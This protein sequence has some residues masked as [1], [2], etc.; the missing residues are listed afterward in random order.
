[1]ILPVLLLAGLQSAHAA[2]L[3]EPGCSARHEA[4]VL[5]LADFR[6][7]AEIEMPRAGKRPR[8]VA[9]L[10]AG[11]DVA[12][13]DGAIVGGSGKI[14]SRP[15][16]QVADRLA[17]AGY[18]SVRYNKRYVADATTVDR[19]RFDRLNGADLVADGRSAVALARARPGLRGVPIVLVGWS[20][21]TTVAM[22][23]AAAEPGVRAI[24]LMAP[25]TNAPA[26]NA[27]TQYSRVGKPYLQRYASVGALDATAI[28]A[29]DAGPGGLLAHVFVRMFRGFAPG[30]RINPLLDADKDGRISFAEADPTIASWYADT[31]DGGLGIDATGRALPGVADAYPTTTQPVLILQGMNDGNVDV[32]AT[33][34]FARRPDARRRVTLLTYPGLGHSLG[35]ARSMLE[36]ALAPTSDRPLDDMTHWLDRTLSSGRKRSSPANGASRYGSP[37]SRRHRSAGQGGKPPR[38]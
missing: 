27:Q 22:A 5:Q 26:R 15:L 28:A 21:G 34:A 11:S 1:M 14:V 19:S 13:K 33:R 7:P 36:D 9:V 2:I 4:V 8:G 24:V 25:V 20:Q 32:A 38:D 3:A 37:D 16:G 29:A 6:S 18:A 30:E 23:V 31:P 10:L 12:D 35:P 17:C